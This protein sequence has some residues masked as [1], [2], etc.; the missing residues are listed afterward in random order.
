METELVPCPKCACYVRDTEAA[1]P[2]C[3]ASFGRARGLA[4]PLT[5]AAIAMSLAAA[6]SFAGCSGADYG[7]GETGGGD[8]SGDTSTA[9]G[10]GGEGGAGGAGG[11]NQ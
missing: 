4:L 5:A 2:M 1:C 10:E 8:P 6:G 7:V 9:S 3:S 11:A